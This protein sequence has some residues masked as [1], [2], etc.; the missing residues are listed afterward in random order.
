MDCESW[1]AGAEDEA[2]LGLK[3]RQCS[4]RKSG[5]TVCFDYFKLTPQ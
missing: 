4:S 2:E 1:G 3:Q 5:Y